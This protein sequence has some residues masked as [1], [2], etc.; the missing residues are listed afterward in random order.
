MHKRP[1]VAALL[2]AGGLITVSPWTPAAMAAP[3]TATDLTDFIVRLGGYFFKDPVPATT[4]QFSFAQASYKFTAPASGSNVITIVKTQYDAVTIFTGNGTGSS[5]PQTPPPPSSTTPANPSQQLY[6]CADTFY[7]IETVTLDVRELQASTAAPTPATFTT[8]TGGSGGKVINDPDGKP[9]QMWSVTLQTAKRNGLAG[10]P[11][12][13]RVNTQTLPANC[14]NPATADPL[15]D[16]SSQPS[17][18]ISQKD[19]NQYPIVFATQDQ[20]IYFQFLLNGFVA[21]TSVP[22]SLIGAATGP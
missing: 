9:I 14:A 22:V 18:S 1:A 11:N 3:P 16:T 8:F 7:F 19:V 17:T 20:A 10:P 12:L 13:I 6:F 5:S 4:G 21:A 2:L 15:L